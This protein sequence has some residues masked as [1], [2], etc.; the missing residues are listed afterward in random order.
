MTPGAG[1][2]AGAASGARIAQ[3]SGARRRWLGPI[4]ALA[5][6][7]GC[8]VLAT[9]PA[10]PGPRDAQVT[11]A[12]TSRFDPE[13]FAGRWHVVAAFGAPSGGTLRQFT[14][15][16]EQA[17]M[18]ETGPAQPRRYRVTAP[19]VLRPLAPTAPDAPDALV[20]MWVDEGFRTAVLGTPSG[21]RGE[22]LDR[23]PVAAPDRL[24]A[25]KEILDFNG[26]DVSRLQ[27][28]TK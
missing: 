8:G 20:V 13:R 12:G 23:A 7:G 2:A 14:Y 6:L 5:L 11:I 15:D 27:K 1:C 28:V 21:Q 9:L 10:G 17:V 4:A 18:T 26:W 22:I 24:A 19:G 16:P 25:A 3:G